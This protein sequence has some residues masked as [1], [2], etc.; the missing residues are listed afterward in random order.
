MDYHGIDQEIAAIDSKI[1]LLHR[2]KP[3]NLIYEKRKFFKD[4]GRNPQ[5]IYKPIPF[6]LD[7]LEKNLRNLK[8]DRTPLGMIFKHKIY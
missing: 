8:S 7:I 2:L 1:K 4:T 5:F 3:V 6:D